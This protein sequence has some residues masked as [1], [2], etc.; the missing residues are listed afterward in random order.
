MAA[1]P[2]KPPPAAP[3]PPPTLEALFAQI[4]VDGDG[5]LSA[6][7]LEKALIVVGFAP[8]ERVA[9]LTALGCVEGECPIGQ[10]TYEE[11]EEGLPKEARATIEAR[12]TAEGVLPSLYL[13]PE[14]YTR[15]DAKEKAAL[16]WEQKV[17][18][19]AIKEGNQL[20]QNDILANELGKM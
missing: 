6:V 17:Q 13:P 2:A 3:T 19:Q 10:V 5:V 20:R 7:E 8:T 15:G 1:G 11:F 14:A 12:L 16:K 4:D 9:L 18:M